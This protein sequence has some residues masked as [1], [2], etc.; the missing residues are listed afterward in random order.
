MLA[1]IEIH[2]GSLI[3]G[4][5]VRTIFISFESNLGLVC[6]I[7]TSLSDWSEKSRHSL[8]QSDK[9]LLPTTTWSPVFSGALASLVVLYFSSLGLL[10]VFPFLLIGQCDYDTQ[11]K[12]ALIDRDF[13]VCRCVSVSVPQWSVNST[14]Q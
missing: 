2:E 7:F 6:F 10:K 11:S 3:C 8:N 4:R 5:L 9:K 1:D 12:S 14:D 13:K